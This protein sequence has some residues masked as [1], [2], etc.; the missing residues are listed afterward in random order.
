MSSTMIIRMFL[1]LVALCFAAFGQWAL[2]QPIEMA[3]QLGVTV[4]GRNG[5]YELAGIYGGVS[6]AAA[7]L[8]A[9]G[10]VM[11][12][13]RRPALWFLVTYMGG[14]VFARVAAWGLHGPP[15]SDFYVFIAFEA[16]VLIGALFSLTRKF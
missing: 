10:A 5:A 1:I 6:F 9:A 7:I 16:A 13:M 4:S 3:S 11:K 2:F 15:S 12:R 8:C 14:Y